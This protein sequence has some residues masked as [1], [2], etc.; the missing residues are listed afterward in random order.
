MAIRQ[1]CL[2]CRNAR[3]NNSCNIQGQH[4]IFDGSSCQ[5]YS[6]AT[7]TDTQTLNPPIIPPLDLSRALSSFM[8]KVYM[9]MAFALLVTALTAHF[10]VS[11]EFALYFIFENNLIF[12]G[13]LIAE[14]VLV[15][16][17]SGAINKISVQTATLLFVIYSILNGVTISLIFLLYTSESITSTFVVTSLTFGAMSLYGISTK[18]DLTK[19]GQILIFALFGLII[20]T[21]ANI[22]LENSTLY[23]ITTYI[24]VLIFVGLT[25]YDTQKLKRIAEQNPTG[26]T[27]A[28]LSILG[29]LILYLDFINLFLFLL[30][31]FGRRK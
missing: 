5:Q 10:V 11:S 27:M 9:W 26:D 22:F 18:R 4:L 8:T 28:K 17:I 23:W 20:A 30:R 12:Y 13:I 2:N 24:G 19:I 29:A 15:G 21:V 7:P 3:A 6:S 16:V 25:A 31:I 14:L 1:Q